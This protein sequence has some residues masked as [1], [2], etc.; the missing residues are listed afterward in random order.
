MEA[1]MLPPVPT[2]DDPHYEYEL[3][4]GK[5]IG[6]IILPGERGY[7][8]IRPWAEI[9]ASGYIMPSEEEHYAKEGQPVT[10]MAYRVPTY[11]N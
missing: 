11:L 4:T 6:P 2:D 9:R 1:T 7:G 5:R 3:G 8:V 10:E